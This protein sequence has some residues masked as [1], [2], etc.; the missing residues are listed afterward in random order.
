MKFYKQ[1]RK[2]GAVVVAGASVALLSASV[3]A[4]SLLPVGALTTAGTDAKD[5]ALEIS[6]WAVGLIA[7][8][9]TTWFIASGTRKGLGKAGVK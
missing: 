8:L 3:H 6:L 5:T 9:Q 7:V 4:A 2:Y 1:A